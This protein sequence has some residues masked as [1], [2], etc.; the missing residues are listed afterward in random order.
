MGFGCRTSKHPFPAPQVR[1]IKLALKHQGRGTFLKAQLFSSYIFG[2]NYKPFGTGA[3]SEQKQRLLN[4]FLATESAQSP[5]F[6]KHVASI[7]EDLGMPCE[8]DA[9][10]E[11][12]W[13]AA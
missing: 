5:V 12:I 8:T 10:L 13:R 11:A 4:V 7:A 9:D 3:F 6:L 2:L 1:D